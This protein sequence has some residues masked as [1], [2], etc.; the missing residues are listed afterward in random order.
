M[1]IFNYL[2]NNLSILD[3]ISEYVPL[4]M[5]GNYHKGPCPFHFEKEASFTVSP[6]KGI[7]YCFGCHAKG[8]IVSF[9]EKKENL[10][11]LQ[12][13]KYLIDKY[14]IDL[15]DEIKQGFSKKGDPFL[16]NNHFNSCN[17]FSE[18]ATQK[19]LENKIAL[20]YLKERNIDF[21]LI[22]YFKIG[23]FPGGAKNIN[24]L[25]RFAG[26]EKIIAKDL[27]EAGILI[28]S[29]SVLYSP[30]EERI[31]FP[32]NDLLSRCCGFGGR[33]FRPED[34]RAKYYNS[35]DALWFSKGKLL[36]GFDKAKEFLQEKKS[37]FLVEGYTDT[38]AMV[39]YGYKN[40]V[41]TLGT[42][43]TADHLKTLSRYVDT[44]YVLYDGDQAGQNAI[45]R[46]TQ[47]C[48]DVNLELTIITLPKKDDPA[49]FL[50]KN[51]TLD[52]LINKSKNIF[53]FFIDIISKDFSNKTLSDKMIIAKKILQLIAKIDDELKR[54]ILLQQ[55]SKSL[56]LPISSLKSLIFKEKTELQEKENKTTYAS[57]HKNQPNNISNSNDLSVPALEQKIFS[58]IINSMN[59]P[60]KLCVP[61]DL[62]KYFSEYIQS[63]LK[64]LI[65]FM[66]KNDGSIKLFDLFLKTLNENDRNWVVATSLK[67]EQKNNKQTFDELLLLFCKKYWK[68]IVKDIKE[69][70]LIAQQKKDITRVENLFKLFSDLKNGIK[71]RGLI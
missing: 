56:E 31:L 46:L 14:Q 62:I 53:S 34:E 18:W 67:F 32:I 1:P 40:V 52:E 65:T 19:L 54:E 28:Q 66:N 9:I 27:I 16:K 24:N 68:E 13:A 36:F 6:D 26:N 61:E 2:K 50:E 35:K 41:A 7:F 51:G 37:V 69:K 38:V 10:S 55:A 71:T 15:P 48:W 17:L 60:E 43:C 33:I 20:D 57:T 59:E 47:L 11:A 45:L 22:K 49:T 5:A 21:D 39:K 70:M 64:K 29:R 3:V 23:Y 63:L 4:K 44:V 8:D 42:A 25:L 58:V 12:A 30:F